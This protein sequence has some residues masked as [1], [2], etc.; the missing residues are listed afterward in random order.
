MQ[1]WEHDWD[2]D[3]QLHGSVGPMG[4]RNQH[5][6]PIIIFVP[7]YCKS[8]RYCSCTTRSQSCLKR[9]SDK[10]QAWP[11]GT[12]FAPVIMIFC[13]FCARYAGRVVGELWHL[14]H[15][16]VRQPNWLVCKKKGQERKG[17]RSFVLS[18]HIVVLLFHQIVE[19]LQLS[20]SIIKAGKE[21]NASEAPARL[22]RRNKREELS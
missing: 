3:W 16:M 9:D 1:K 10:P 14:I 19:V 18:I 7:I 5:M 17:A 11:V 4:Q 8:T 15:S 6:R 21:I 13:I 22:G 2:H 20:K 12:A